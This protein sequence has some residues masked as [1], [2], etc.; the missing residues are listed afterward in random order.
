MHRD[1]SKQDT[2]RIRYTHACSVRVVFPVHGGETL[3]VVKVASVHSQSCGPLSYSHKFL[4]IPFLVERSGRRMLLA[5]RS[6]LYFNAKGYGN[7]MR[8]PQNCDFTECNILRLYS[9]G[10][11]VELAP[12]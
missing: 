1:Y 12:A 10:Y 5:G 6:A 2:R 4:R 11:G 9:T 8:I 7:R 3:G